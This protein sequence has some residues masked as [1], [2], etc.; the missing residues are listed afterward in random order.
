MPETTSA[1]KPVNYILKTSFIYTRN[2]LI[3]V[4]LFSQVRQYGEIDAKEYVPGAE[5]LAS[6]KGK[7]NTDD[8]KDK[9][10]SKDGDSDSDSWVDI[11]DNKDDE[12]EI[13]SDSDGSED[14]DDE[15]GDDDE[16]VEEEEGSSDEEE[17]DSG[18]EIESQ[19]EN[20]EP[21]AK[22]S[23]QNAD[24]TIGTPRASR[25]KKTKLERKKEK[26]A[27]LKKSDVNKEEILSQRKEKAEEISCNRI[28]T[29][30]DFERIESAQA[31]KVKIGFKALQL[32]KKR[33]NNAALEMEE[34]K[35]E[36][37]NLGDI[38]NIHKRKK[39][40]KES[41]LETVLKGREGREKW[42]YKKNRTN[43]HASTTNTTL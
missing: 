24:D 6:N 19:V 33:K 32:G 15:S 39:H 35:G 36:L 26:L 43:P 18:D 21:S 3:H 28:L 38:E 20:E 40:D 23:K 41:R 2:T 9:V 27:R 8:P 13:D 10:E 7:K 17:E 22:K 16:D 29:D 11:S 34:S 31:K 4:Q 37:V 25:K 14:V 42:G 5:V 1:I 12:I 30:E